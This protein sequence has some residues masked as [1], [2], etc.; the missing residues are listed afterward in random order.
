MNNPPASPADRSGWVISAS[1]FGRLLIGGMLSSVLSA[2]EPP[3][4]DEPEDETPQA[5]Q[6]QLVTA[7]PERRSEAL[8]R[9]AAADPHL[10]E[11][12]ARA[13][14]AD[15]DERTQGAALAVLSA[16]GYL[17][18]DER[19]IARRLL[20]GWDRGAAADAIAAIARTRDDGAIPDLLGRMSDADPTIRHHARATLTMFAGKDLGDDLSAWH[21]WQERED[22]AAQPTIDR[23]AKAVDGADV[24]GVQQALASMSFLKNHRMAVVEQLEIAAKSRD[25]AMARVAL[26]TLQGLGRPIDPERLAKVAN[27]AIPPP[28]PPASEAAVASRGFP[29]W[30]LALLVVVMAGAAWGIRHLQRYA[31]V[32]TVRVL[33]RTT[34]LL[35]RKV[36]KA[37]T[38][39]QVKTTALTAQTAQ[40]EPGQGRS[41]RIVALE[42]D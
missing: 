28:P 5:V 9:A 21:D 22:A 32:P 25:P 31:K 30:L 29:W 8:E 2:A 3:E 4:V 35:A 19:Q 12:T 37:T 38:R 16:D 26:Q 6:Q 20:S 18:P 27:A 39:K 10:A 33:S 11:A 41:G 14:I 42:D 34:R 40:T 23:L 1:A 17:E 24:V 15:G 13:W 36:A 7:P